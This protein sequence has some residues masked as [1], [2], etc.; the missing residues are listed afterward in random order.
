MAVEQAPAPVFLHGD[1]QMSNVLVSD[2]HTFQR[3]NLFQHEY[4]ALLDW[5]AS[6]WG[7][8]AFDFA[9]V[10]LGVVPLMLEGYADVLPDALNEGFR[11]CILHR[12][13]HLA[14]FLL[15]RPPLPERSWAERPHGMMLEILRFFAAD[16]PT[17]WRP[18]A[19]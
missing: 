17:A 8:A 10:P 3:E 6:G 18:L 15:R 2:A 13:L 1:I 4:L 16:P 11:A 14:L 19:P 5:G 7:D 12:H 9:G